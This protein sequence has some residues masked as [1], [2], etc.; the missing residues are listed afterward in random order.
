MRSIPSRLV[1]SFAI[2]TDTFEITVPAGYVV[3][4]LPSP[5]NADSSLASYQST[6]GAHLRRKN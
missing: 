1:G 2:D 6:T 5:V 4:D 3:D